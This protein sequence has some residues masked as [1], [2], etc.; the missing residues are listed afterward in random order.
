VKSSTSKSLCR[1]V[2]FFTHLGTQTER[3]GKKK[4]KTDKNCAGE[5]A[6]TQVETQKGCGET[7]DQRL[8]ALRQEPGKQKE[9]KES[10]ASNTKRITG[11]AARSVAIKRERG[12]KRGRSRADV[13]EKKTRGVRA[14]ETN[15]QSS[16]QGGTSLLFFSQD[17]EID[18]FARWRKRARCREKYIRGRSAGV[19]RALTTR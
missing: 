11:S 13:Q 19:D 12:V 5:V 9:E 4:K 8:L 14:K 18:T 15:R 16:A 2:L 10:G 1:A 6:R 7:I 17:S 3:G